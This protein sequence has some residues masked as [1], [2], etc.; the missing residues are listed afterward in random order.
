MQ[1]I[2]DAVDKIAGSELVKK[3]FMKVAWK[4]NYEWRVYIEKIYNDQEL[5]S[6]YRA[7]RESESLDSKLEKRDRRPLIKFPDM[8]IYKFL[9]DIFTKKYGKGWL[10]D[11]QTLRKII[12]QED[13][14]KPWVIVKD[15]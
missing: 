14:I 4:L 12:K 10:R 2:S 5:T 13:L 11:K 3:A 6:L 9:D 1:N 8:I 15:L 7:M